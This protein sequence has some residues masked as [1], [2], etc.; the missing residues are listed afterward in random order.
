MTAT[1]DRDVLAIDI[2]GTKIALAIVSGG[3]VTHRLQMATPRSGRGADIV[4]AIASQATLLPVT[5][6]AGVATTGI[7]DGGQ[8]TALNPSTL[9]IED[10]FPLVAALEARL[11][12]PVLAINDAQAAAC[13][14]YRLGAGQGAERMAFITVSTGI[15]A[16][17]VLD[18]RLQSGSRGL[19]GHVGHMVSDPNGPVC[20]CGRR[21]CV[22]R[23]ASGSAIALLASEMLRRNVAAPEVFAA[24]AAG[25]D[26]C[27]QLLDQAATA[28]AGTLCDLVAS[29]DLERIV[30]G[31]GV[32]LA[33]GFLTRLQAAVSRQPVIYRRQIVR[34]AMGADAGLI[35]V[36]SLVSDGKFH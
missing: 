19:A 24:S 10:R 20:G 18:G 4:E 9:P 22:E 25:D 29:L 7:V 12:R 26:R 2:G 16:G 15:G 8:L 35:G 30:L 1:S 36:A 31:G 17:I 33:D 32:G 13:A 6:A 28:L 14:E 5:L 21:G 34:A 11:S 23:L 27:T 3:V